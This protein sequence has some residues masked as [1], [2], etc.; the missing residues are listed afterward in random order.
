MAWCG[1]GVGSCSLPSLDN[2]VGLDDDEVGLDEVGL[3]E[4][5]VGLE[6]EDVGLEEGG[7]DEVDEVDL[8]AGGEGRAEHVFVMAV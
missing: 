3:D 7:L 2:G 6:D 1:R 8:E 5:E 4:D